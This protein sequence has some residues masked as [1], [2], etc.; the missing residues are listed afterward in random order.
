MGLWITVKFAHMTL[1]LAPE[2]LD[3]VDIIMFV[4]P[5]GRK[6]GESFPVGFYQRFDLPL[7]R[8]SLK[9]A[10]IQTFWPAFSDDNFHHA[11]QEL[12]SREIHHHCQAAL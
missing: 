4:V 11:W 2:I 12:H 3:P 5:V 1:G 8:G 9:N 7:F 6:A 10:N